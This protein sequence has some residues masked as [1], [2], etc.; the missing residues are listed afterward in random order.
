M[1]AQF[2][3][4]E[5]IDGSGKTTF[6]KKLAKKVN[7]LYT[8][9]PTKPCKIYQ[10]FILDR[11]EHYNNV[12]KPALDNGISVICDRY[13]YSTHAYQP[14]YSKV[15]EEE[16]FAFE[17]EHPVVEP[18][19]IYFIN[20]NPFKARSRMEKEGRQLDEYEENIIKQWQVYKRYKAMFSKL[21]KIK[22]VVWC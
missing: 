14:V 7:G 22:K 12:I 13:N 1:A 8:H 21:Y 4:V 11:E 6:A 9:L 10:D 19:L 5:G 17:V 3:V 16:I 2:I 15:S 18:D 20:I